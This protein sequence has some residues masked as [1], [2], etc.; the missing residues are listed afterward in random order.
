MKLRCYVDGSPLGD[1]FYLV[2][3]RNDSDRVFVMDAECVKR[4][5]KGTLICAVKRVKEKSG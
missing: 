4:L 2:S 1:T 5:E 3:M